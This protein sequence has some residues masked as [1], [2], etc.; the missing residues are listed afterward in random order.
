MVIV[1]CIG[2]L[3]FLSQKAIG[4]LFNFEAKNFTITGSS[5]AI[6]CPEDITAYVDETC[7][8]QILLELPE[9]TCAITSI[10]YAIDGGPVIVIPIGSL[11]PIS[12]GSFPPDTFNVV[13][14][15]IDNC[16]PPTNR[17][18]TQTIF[19]QDTISPIIICPNDIS[20]GNSSDGRRNAL[21]S[22]PQ[23]DVSDNCSILLIENDFNNTDDA[24]DTYQFGTT[25]VIWTVTDIHGNTSSCIMNV[26]VFDNTKPILT[27]PNTLRSACVT[28]E[29]YKHYSDYIAA[30]GSAM[31]E[32]A[33]DTSTFAWVEDIDT[34][35]SCPDTII[36]KYTIG[37]TNGNFDTCTQLLIVYDT[38]APTVICK[39]IT[40]N[41]DENGQVTIAA[42]SL[43]NGSFDNCNGDLIFT[44]NFTLFFGCNDIISGSTQ[45]EAILKVTDQCGNSATCISTITVMDLI[46]PTIN[47]PP[48]LNSDNDNNQCYASGISLGTPITNDNCGVAITQPTFLGIT[49][50]YD[51][52]FPV[53]SNDVVWTVTDAGG[54][55]ATCV[56]N[57]IVRDN[58]SPII[59]CPNSITANTTDG[60]CSAI[61]NYTTPIGTD[62][63]SGANT[64]Q[65][66]GLPSGS[67]FP[68]GVTTNTFVVTANNG[69]T[70]SC[71][72]TV[73]VVDNQPPTI[74]CTTNITTNTDPNLCSA[75]VN[76]TTPSGNDNCSGA[77]T[78]QTSGLPSGSTFP[79]GVTTN[80]FVVT[81]NNGQTASCSFTVTVLDNQPPSISCPTNITTNNNPN[82]CSAIVN[83]ITPVGTDNCPGVTTSQTSGLAN[84]STFP[85]GIMTN[86]FLATD[87]NGL[88]ASCAFTLTVVDNQPP[89]ISCPNNIT[90]A[91]SNSCQLVV[92]N[93]S[94]SVT[95]SDNCGVTTV[96][97]SPI[98]GT[99]IPSSHNQTHP[100]TFTVTDAAGLTSTCNTVITSIDNVGPDI[101]CEGFRVLSISDF[102]EVP[103]SSFVISAVDNCGGLLTYSARRMGNLCGSNTPDDFGN[104]VNFC[105]DDVNDTIMVVVRVTDSRGNFTDCMN[106]VAVQDKLAPN[107]I[108]GSLPDISVSCAY[109]L[110][111]NDLSAFGTIVPQG[112][113]R[114]NIV[115]NDPN[116]PFYPTGIAGQDGEYT[117]NCPGATVSVTSRNLL[118]MCNTGQIKRD[119]LITDL[120]GNTAT[121]TQTIHVIDVNKFNINDITWPPA[122][123]NYNNCNDNNPSINITGQPILKTDNC[124]LAGAAYVDQV[125]SNPNNCGFIK[126]TW[127]VLD[128][129][130]YQTNNPGGPGKWTFVQS[131]MI[132]NTVAPVIDAKVCRDTMICTGNG[133]DATVTFNASGSD[134]C[135]P[136]S[137]V[138]T[139]K[140]DL[141]NNGSIDANGIGNTITRKYNIGKH[142]ITWEA[143]DKCGNISTCSSLFTIRDCKSPSAVALNGL[144]LS[145]LP[146][147]GQASIKAKDFNKS[148]SD[149]CTPAPQ[150]KY[151]FSADVNDNIRNFNCDSLG[152]RRI[153][154]WV[155]DLAG[156]QSKAITYIIVQ[157]NID[158]CGLGNKVNIKG[159]VYTE[160]KVKISDTKVSID[161]GETD[162]Y[163]MTNVDGQY[164]FT[165]LAKYNNYEL[166]PVKDTDHSQGI[167]TLDLVLIQR[168]I[169]GIK[170]LD[171]PYKMIA[172]DVN[173]SHN[174]TAA[175]LVELRKLILG[176]QSKFSKNTSW[177]FVDATYAFSD[178]SNPWP[179]AERLNYEELSTSMEHSDFIAVKIGDV[180]GTVSQNIQG[181]TVS[182]NN[183]KLNL[184]F[185]EYDV[186]ANEIITI[187]IMAEN[188][189]NYIGMQ[190]TIELSTDMEYMG[191]ES[192]DLPLGNDHMALVE[193][194]GR[195]YL[196]LSYDEQS[197]ITLPEGSVLF[198]IICRPIR[199]SKISELLWMNDA[200]TTS[201][202]YPIEEV[203]SSIGLSSRNIKTETN[204]FFMQ[205][206]PNPFKDETIIQF[207]LSEKSPVVLSIFDASGSMVSKSNDIYNAGNHTLVLTEK[208]LG[209]KYGVFFCKIK[210]KNLEQ[211]IKILRIE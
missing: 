194:N 203:P 129:C 102:P 79:I 81:S 94:S 105:C 204:S 172:A 145:L 168:H 89:S 131:I 143:K 189:S 47:C 206:H 97:Q 184:Y 42:D 51:T 6:N 11:G 202:A 140:I 38:I 116:N 18:C 50:T 182:R 45:I 13:W 95:V 177:R 88:T 155:T 134:D 107:V 14:T 127:T 54:N 103:A 80:I 123:V 162:D 87:K 179:F 192:V 138:W 163:L 122:N 186:K 148:S 77:T 142:K 71:S 90:V 2:S 9:S 167:T 144:A 195:K 126:R 86:T 132:T 17:I 170:Q 40:V 112:T 209:S 22:I 65:T 61:V 128:W 20:I 108:V 187:P 158:I 160:E 85:V 176:V 32:T 48:I 29:I 147:L 75:I 52:E 190:W 125:F 141:D 30:G 101:V 33:V 210:T 7:E 211:I 188:L 35:F 46:L 100:I 49:V 27:C 139:Y 130:Q 146:P 110:N 37:D 74:T 28:N 55:T 19:I 173:N 136:V 93:L 178:N 63:C 82:L 175:D 99:V 171:S 174:I 66:S 154:F 10:S 150:L 83:Y 53:G 60:L 133:C 208:Q 72:F 34:T 185:D 200:V 12:I 26:I 3:L 199:N 67:T 183:N 23:P 164:Y 121:Y 115:I 111:L 91:L 31:D 201:E 120:G 98:S 59:S 78:T 56:Q 1:A 119:F 165:D 161:G 16:E 5:F 64:T 104:Y 8:V 191:F 92:P 73:T 84:G 180:N 157:D 137:I 76:Y 57:V 62:N 68:I 70:S 113:T 106:R 196:T 117:D 36:R 197:G 152:Q 166:L 118:T 69:Q 181:Q 151:S 24:S 25:V 124:N 109:L 114:K 169:L 96:T 156:N 207:S 198:N 149:N 15:V 43:D 44:S 193:K 41:L 4:V 205:N 58:E 21:I 153:E 159:Q 135:L 39:D